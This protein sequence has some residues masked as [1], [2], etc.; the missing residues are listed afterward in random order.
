MKN[1]P[2]AELKFSARDFGSLKSPGGGKVSLQGRRLWTA[3]VLCAIPA[4]VPFARAATIWNGP[5]T[6]FTQVNPYP[7]VGDRDTITANVAITRGLTA[8]IFNAVSETGYTHNS[9]P[10]GTEWAIGELANYASLTYQSWEQ[11][12]GSR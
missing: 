8:G 5:T 12:G 6:N 4:C 11:T 10:S 9:S 2:P 3:F 1:S 7:G